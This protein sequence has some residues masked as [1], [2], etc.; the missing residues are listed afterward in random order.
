MNSHYLLSISESGIDQLQSGI[1][2]W[3]ETFSD[4]LEII[5]KSPD[6]LYPTVW[7]AMQTI[8]GYLSA[9]GASLILIFFYIGLTKNTLHFENLRRPEVFFGYFIRIALAEGVVSYG[10]KLLLTILQIFQGCISAIVNMESIS[11]NSGKWAAVPDEIT[12]LTNEAGTIAGIGIFAICAIGSILI[13]A[14]GIVMLLIVYLRFFKIYI[15]AAVS[16][17]PLSTIAG[18]TTSRIARSFIM[19]YIAICFQGIVIAIAFIIFA[20]VVD[21][22]FKIETDKSATYNLFKYIGTVLLQELLLVSTVRASDRL[23][24]EMIGA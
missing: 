5:T 6:H 12:A 10:S 15:Y 16:P 9:I 20:K 17:I 11:E 13:W 23:T 21:S 18:E 1:D 2:R 8:N 24:K 3:N 19:N 7:S 22:G 14:L 4:I